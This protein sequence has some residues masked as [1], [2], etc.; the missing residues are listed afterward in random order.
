MSH[1]RQRIESLQ[2]QYK[3]YQHEMIKMKRQMQKARLIVQLQ[4]DPHAPII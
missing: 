4:A 1:L 2:E 3:L